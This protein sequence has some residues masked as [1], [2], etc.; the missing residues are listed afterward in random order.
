MKDIKTILQEQAGDLG[1]DVRSAIEKAVM[2]NYRTVNEVN[3]KADKIAQLEA[4]N[5]EAAETIAAMKSAG[6][7]DAEALKAAQAKIAEFEKAEEQRKTNE[8]DKQARADFADEFE[9]ALG[10]K[11]FS[12]SIVGGAVTEAAYKMRSANPDMPIADIIKATAPDEPGIWENPQRSPHKM[13]ESTKGSG[14]Q[15]VTSLEQIKTMTPNEI[16]KNWDAVSKLLAA[17]K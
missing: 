12:N 10:G 15:E 16:N 2:E 13:P 9:K 4:A 11:K 17:Q 5:K 3:S 8:A 14:L 7:G 6:E 1:E